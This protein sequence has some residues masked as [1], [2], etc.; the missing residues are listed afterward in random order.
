MVGRYMIGLFVM[1][2]DWLIGFVFYVDWLV[3]WLVCRLVAILLL[4]FRWFV[5]FVGLVP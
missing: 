1:F 4:G 2:L 5:G 3:C